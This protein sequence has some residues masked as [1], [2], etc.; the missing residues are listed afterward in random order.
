MQKMK[1]LG[2]G[3]AAA[4]GAVALVLGLGSAPAMALGS[5]DEPMTLTGPSSVSLPTSDY[6][7]LT[8]DFQFTGP[9]DGVTYAA[10]TKSKMIARNTAIRPSYVGK[11]FALAEAEGNITPDTPYGIPASVHFDGTTPGKYQLSVS[12]RQSPSDVARTVTK[13]VTVKANT[14]FSKSITRVSSPSVRVGS[15]RTITV[16][17]PYYQVGATVYAYYKASGQTTYKKVASAKLVNSSVSYAKASIR[18]SGKYTKTSG[19]FYFKVAAAPY[20]GSYQTASVAARIVR[21]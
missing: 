17:A 18:V 13:D 12:V 14:K 20:A 19:R 9:T 7:D 1:K 6:K 10:E 15:A 2:L 21:S 8:Y 3:S 5:F 11:Y 4:T 16:K